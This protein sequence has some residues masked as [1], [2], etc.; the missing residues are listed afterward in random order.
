MATL[1]VGGTEQS[2]LVTV[3]V[4]GVSLGVFDTW[5]GGDSTAAVAQHRSGG[6]ANQTSYQ[7]LPKFSPITVG[8]VMQTTR[9]WTLIRTLTPKAGKVTA[10]VTI[11]PLDAT[12]NAYGSSRTAT[13]MFQGVKS[14]KGDS[15]SEA[16]QTYELDITVDSWA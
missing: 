9:D 1:P 14:L 16:L 4:N 12:R 6:Q 2:E 5:S 10:S 13:G 3:V 15:N 7:T 8:R 11:Q